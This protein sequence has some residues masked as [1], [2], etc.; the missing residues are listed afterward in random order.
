[1]RLGGT[2]STVSGENGESKTVWSVSRV[3]YGVPY[4]VLVAGY[5]TRTV[6]ILRLWKAEAPDEFDYDV[7]SKG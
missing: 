4:D 6:S 7:F 5:G 3:I 1:V 2:L